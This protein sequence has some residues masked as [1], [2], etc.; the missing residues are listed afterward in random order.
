MQINAFHIS[1]VMSK[2]LFEKQ[3]QNENTLRRNENMVLDGTSLGEIYQ[4]GQN[5]RKVCFTSNINVNMK[6][7][8]YDKKCAS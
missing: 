2:H 5:G 1:L 3:L 6:R 7:A 8:N 4:S